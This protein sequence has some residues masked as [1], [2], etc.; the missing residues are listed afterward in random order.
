M[1]KL[2]LS[3]LTAISPLDGRYRSRL[4]ELADYFSELALIRTRF[5]IEAKYLIVLSD[6]GLV[7][8]LTAKERRILTSF[9]QEIDLARAA[10]VKQIEQETRHDVK[11][12]EKAFREIVARTS[13]ADLAEMIH[14][15]LTSEDVNN[16]AYRLMLVRAT[17]NVCLPKLEELTSQLVIRA[18]KYKATPMLART[19]GQAA[20]P[21]TLGKELVVFAD[22]LN[23]QVKRLD[24]QKLF[25]K[26]T[27]AVGN[28]NAHT[29][30]APDINWIAVSQNFVKSFGF[31]PNLVT[32]QINPY[33]DLIEYLQIYARINSIIINFD[34]DM[35]RYISDDWFIQEVKRGEVG[36]STM[37]QK[38]NPI[39]FENSEGNLTMAAGL[40][41]TLARKLAVTRLQRDLSDSTLI[42]NLG[43]VLGHSL[44]GWQSALE[45]L[46]RVRPNLVK[47]AK[48]LQSDWSVLAEG[49]QTLLKRHGVKDPYSLVTS[50]A[51]G[52][53]FDQNSWQTFV[54]ELPQDNKVKAKL[55]NFSPANYIGL[56]IKLTELAIGQI[57]ASRKK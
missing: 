28:F 5:E 2:Q 46:A 24:Q 34:Q 42:R 12:L 26:L 27:G 9:G 33:D 57:K 8:K 50:V 18:Q 17:H 53:H 47:I 49:V 10:R 41:E 14:F 15:G 45:G 35:W 22:R 36:S 29:L 48:D 7:R 25:G 43:T 30:A 31:E 55:T 32:T 19:H 54:R 16:L 4:A 6:I 38:V 11:A 39:D 51:R 20:V 1:D 21:T 13:L 52:E 44:L 3:E 37:P 40:I 23:R 56:A